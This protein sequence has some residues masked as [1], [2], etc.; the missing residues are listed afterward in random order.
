MNTPR[1]RGRLNVSTALP[2]RQPYDTTYHSPGRSASPGNIESGV[3]S[4]HLAGEV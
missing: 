1:D 3:E 4:R 2:S